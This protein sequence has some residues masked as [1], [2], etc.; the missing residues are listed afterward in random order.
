MPGRQYF[1]L[2]SAIPGFVFILLLIIINFVPLMTFIEDN[3]FSSTVTVFLTILSLFSGSAIGFLI[4]QGHWYNW[5][6]NFGIITLEEYRPSIIEFLK[7]FGLKKQDIDE[8]LKKIKDQKDEDWLRQLQSAVDYMSHYNA[9]EKILKLSQRRWDMFHT[10]SVTK[11]ALKWGLIIG[12]GTRIILF[13]FN[14]IS[15]LLYDFSLDV[16]IPIGIQIAFLIGLILSIYF[17]SDHLEK[18]TIWLKKISG[19][20]HKTRIIHSKLGTQK[21]EIKKLELQKLEN[22]KLG[23]QDKLKKIFPDLLEK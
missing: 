5:Q 20:L 12:I 3:A 16:F 11:I 6:K 10:L 23:L 14:E 17:L 13:L 9:D 15:L 18:Q 21:I 2:R 19:H 4:S 22:Q 8:H 7:K 1:D